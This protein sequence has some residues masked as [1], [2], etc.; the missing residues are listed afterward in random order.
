M[1]LEEFWSAPVSS[2][3]IMDEDMTNISFAAD[4]QTVFDNI[5]AA[6]EHFARDP[7]DIDTARVAFSVLTRIMSAWGGPDVAPL[8]GT[9]PPPN[10]PTAQL[11]PA[12]AIPGFDGFAI[13]RLSPLSWA[14]PSSLGFK[15][16]EP[17]SRL[18]VYEIANLQQ[19]IYKKTGVVYVEAL[20]RELSAMGLGPV[21]VE[22]Y[23]QKL[24]G[25]SKGFKEFLT[26][27]LG[28]S[29]E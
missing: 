6:I 22:V 8:T 2:V 13:T 17:G 11:A 1:T 28:R 10:S 18:L 5:I 14:I 24:R 15:A 19:E 9:N 16:T 12:P 21:D 29:G 7:G 20:R 26:K 4:N 3:V 23:V 25:D 27:F